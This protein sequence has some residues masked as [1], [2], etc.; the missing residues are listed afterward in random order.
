MSIFAM[1]KKCYPQNEISIHI[2][3]RIKINIK[4]ATKKNFILIRI[5]I[6]IIMNIKISI[7][8]IINILIRIKINIKIQLDIMM[9]MC[10]YNIIRNIK[11]RIEIMRNNEKWWKTM[12]RPRLDSSIKKTKLS[13]TIS[14][15]A[16]EMLDFIRRENNVSISEFVEDAVRREYKRLRRAGR[17]PDEQIPGQ[18]TIGRD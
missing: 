9:R 16:Q 11:I 3:I 17:V 10:Y 4:I 7:R 6:R 13:L 2:I 1:T 18:I 14:P 15:D 5:I 12:A 8:I